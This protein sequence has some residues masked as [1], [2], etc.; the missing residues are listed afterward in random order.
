MIVQ[1]ASDPTAEPA[2]AFVITMA[3]HTAFAGQLARAFGNDAFEAVEPREAM[4]TIIE[5]HD[6]GWRHLDAEAPSDPETGLPYH[7]VK[8]PFDKIVETS[9]ASPDWNSDRHAYGGLIS[10]M[11]SWGL[12]NGRYGMSDMVLLDMLADDNRAVADRMLDAE[13]ARQETLKAEL[14]RRPETA[15]WLEEDHVFQNYKQLQFFDTLALYFNCTPAGAREEQTFTHVPKSSKE[16]ID[17]AIR[18]AGGDTYALTPYPFASDPLEVTFTGRYLSPREVGRSVSLRSDLE[19]A[20]T[21]SQTV[22]LVRGDA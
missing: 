14:A 7:L 21:G 18:P 11:H 12:Y 19:S 13:L 5:N 16:D 2:R 22:R 8:T 4:L 10:S 3:E 17:I 20:E 15:A 6:V 9:S 1:P